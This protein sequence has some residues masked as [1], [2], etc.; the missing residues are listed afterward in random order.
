MFKKVLIANRGEIAVRV[1]Q[2]CR[3]L[4]I[5]TVAVYSQADRTALH[6]RLADE[7]IEI[8]PAP[9]AESYLKAERILEAAQ[10][11]AA[12]AIHPGYGFLSENAGFAAAVSAAGIS[13][14]GPPAAAISQMGDKLA[15]RQIAQTAGIP[16]V[17]GSQTLTSLDMVRQQAEKIGFPVLLKA[18]AGG[19][20]KGMRVVEQAG[21]LERAF[22]RAQSE[23]QRSFGNP[24]MYMEKFVPRAKHIEMQIFSDAQGNHLW[25]GEREC[26]IQRRQQKLIEESPAATM[27]SEQRLQMGESALTLAKGCGYVNAGTVEFL[28]DADSGDYYFLEMNTRLQV[29]HPVTEMTTGLDLVEWQLLVAAGEK[30]PL[31]QAQLQREGVAIECRLYAE[32]PV[33]FL[34][35]TGQL[36]IFLPPEGAGIRLDSGVSQGDF[37]GSFY[38]PLLAKLIVHGADRQQAIQRMR[39]ALDCFAIAGVTTNLAYHRA[40]MD[41]AVF[42]AGTHLTDFVESHPVQLELSELD[43]NALA[44]IAAHLHE[45]RQQ[46]L[47]EA[48]Q[49][50]PDGWPNQA[51]NP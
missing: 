37:V 33:D 13:W 32:D 20:G 24:Q 34:P 31:T 49:R 44:N 27:T 39:Q 11:T 17:P 48:A 2:T 29:E 4:G 5:K 15:A 6:A 26:S 41:T 8:G 18:T 23:A 46:R 51:W 12:E 25:L 36:R 43:A 30:L 45:Q 47:L 7:A 1:I 50:T 19:G 22:E 42:Q 38:D 16:V 3:R 10:A 14:I 9:A 21:E 40:V 28:Y 35:D